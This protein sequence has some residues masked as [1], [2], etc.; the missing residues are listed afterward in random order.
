MKRVGR[1]VWLIVLTFLLF[2]FISCVRNYDVVIT[3]TIN[4]PVVIEINQYHSKGFDSKPPLE[5]TKDLI[6]ETQRLSLKPGERKTI[7]FNDAAGGFW[8][9]WQ[10]V[11]PVS[12]NKNIH[13]LDLIRDERKIKIIEN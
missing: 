11:E 5:F 4:V 1:H 6:L 9:Q 10:Q 7:S 13:T 8:I 3:N 12:S 2:L